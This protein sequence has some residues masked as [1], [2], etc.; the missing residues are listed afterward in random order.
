MKS[1]II[2]LSIIS[3]M[4]IAEV[5]KDYTYKWKDENPHE[6]LEILWLFGMDTSSMY[7]TQAD[8][9]HKTK[10]GRLVTCDRYVGSERT[11]KEWIESGYASRE[12]KDKFS[13]S[14]LLDDLYRQKGLS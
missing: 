8:V 1:S 3:A 11:D 13:G 4:D 12:A 2:A 7:E 6:F 10:L 5:K 9:T 14:R